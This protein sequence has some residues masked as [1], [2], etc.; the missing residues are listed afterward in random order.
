MCH[1]VHRRQPVW[2]A[3]VRTLA[4]AVFASSVMVAGCAGSSTS[5][6]TVTVDGAPIPT[7]STASATASTSSPASAATP[8][9]LAF[10]NC[11]RA[12]GVPNF[13]DPEPG[14][15]FLFPIPAGFQPGAPAVKTA[16]AKCQRFMPHPPSAP[17]VGSSSA[18]G[19]AQALAQLRGVA[20]C[21][22]RHGIS[23]FPDPQTSRPPNLNLGQY[24]NIT[25]YEG[26]FLLFRAV[27]NMRSPAWQQ[28]ASACGPIAESFNHP[29][30]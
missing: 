24:S 9:A 29:H 7:S 20:Q 8:N 6:T 14:G 13:P 3:Q 4:L 5:T 10:A 26:V 28:A 17:A 12:N 11:M 23:D 30:H 25:N 18:R 15:G 16:Q 21:M 22:R 27:I 1:S 19:R 2:M